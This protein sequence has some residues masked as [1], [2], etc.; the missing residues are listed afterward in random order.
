[1]PAYITQ[2]A[3]TT[4]F[5]S[6]GTI[7]AVVAYLVVVGTILSAVVMTF[8]FGYS[9]RTIQKNVLTGRFDSEKADRLGK[10]FGTMS[11]VAKSN[12]RKRGQPYEKD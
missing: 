11:A 10:W 6:L 8:A 2:T 5:L 1:M 12:A 3:T 9:V 7:D 4:T